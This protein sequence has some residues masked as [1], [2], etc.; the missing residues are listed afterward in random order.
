MGQKSNGKYPSHTFSSHFS[1][2]F[3]LSPS[4]VY[5]T[6]FSSINVYAILHLSILWLYWKVCSIITMSTNVILQSRTHKTTALNTCNRCCSRTTR[7]KMARKPGRNQKKKPAGALAKINDEN[8]MIANA[9]KLG[10]VYYY[11]WAKRT[12]FLLVVIYGSPPRHSNSLKPL[13]N[14][15]KLK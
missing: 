4:P 12:K 9:K 5:S 10:N 6:G 1:F 14:R 15:E 3:P 2:T 11:K 8:E 13:K 7:W